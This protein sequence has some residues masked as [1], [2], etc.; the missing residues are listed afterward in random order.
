MG[1]RQAMKMSI[2]GIGPRIMTPVVLYDVAAGAATWAW[3]RWFAIPWVPY[4]PLLAA[5]SALF[6]LGLVLQ[7]VA[8]RALAKAYC[9][10]RLV[11]TGPYAICRNPLYA[12]VIFTIAPGIALMCRSWPMLAASLLLYVLVRLHIRREETYLENRFG[13]DYIDYRRRTN[14]IFPT[15]YH[16]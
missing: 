13:Q 4:P 7:A 3:P 2:W 11:T 10:D 12:N 5:G 15:I 14:A 9:Q 16:R 6:L 1:S 8:G